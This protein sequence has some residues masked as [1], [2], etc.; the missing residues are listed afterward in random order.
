M[1][2]FSRLFFI[3]LFF[4]TR[5]ADAAS[6][7][8]MCPPSQTQFCLSIPSNCYSFTIHSECT[9]CHQGYTLIGNQCVEKTQEQKLEGEYRISIPQHPETRQ[10]RAVVGDGKFNLSGGC[11]RHEF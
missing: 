9:L 4:S 6:T 2:D 5:P 8:C 10:I 3:L 11:N 1:P 7:P